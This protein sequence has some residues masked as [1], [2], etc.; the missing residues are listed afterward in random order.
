[1]SENIK[2]TVVTICFNAEAVIEKTL[3][4][5]LEQTYTNFEYIVKDGNSTD[6][7]NK[8]IEQYEPLFKKKN[9]QFQHIIQK[10]SGI[11]DAMNQATKLAKGNWI[12]YMNADDIFFD[13]NV[14]N[15]IFENR[16]N[17]QEV[18]YGDS[19]CEYIFYG[20]KKE[21]ALWRGQHASFEKMPFCH[22]AC[23][24]PTKMMKEYLYD[25]HYKSAADFLVLTRFKKDS[26]PFINIHH[27]VS[28]CTMDGVSNTKIKRSYQE[29]VQ[30]KKE[31]NIE[32]ADKAA[33]RAA[34]IA[35][36]VKQW[37][38]MK[39]PR[40]ISG[41]LLRFSVVHGEMKLYSSLE[42][43]KREYYYGQ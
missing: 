26:C 42:L 18:L 15:R 39:V 30:I 33:G 11:Y 32:G 7:T 12:N 29:T 6:N 13:K 19:V 41:R 36:D 28:I 9:I 23:F 20:E 1:M 21:Y 37:I 34:M 16:M 22:Q 17:S 25:T 27:I 40:C 24:L 35:M 31:Y 14:M 4:S 38:L 3:K 10:D 2:V 8:I 43:L 5:V